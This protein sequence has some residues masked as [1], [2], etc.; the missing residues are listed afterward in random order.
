MATN[1]FKRVHIQFDPGTLELVKKIAR[2]DQA[3]FSTTVR[4]LVRKGMRDEVEA[5]EKEKARRSGP[6]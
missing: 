6:V 3:P 1:H 5:M 2:R 4:R